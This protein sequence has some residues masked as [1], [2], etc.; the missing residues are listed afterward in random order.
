MRV[1]QWGRPVHVHAGVPVGIPWPQRASSSCDAG[2][3]L[4]LPLLLLL[5]LVLVLVLLVPVGAQREG[6]GGVC[7]GQL[8]GVAVGRGGVGP[9]TA[10]PPAVLLQ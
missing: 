4:V 10:P 9:A 6:A 8:P 3:F 7:R 2:R 1:V 5:I